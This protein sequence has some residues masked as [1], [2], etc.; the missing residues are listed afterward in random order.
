MLPLSSGLKSSTVKMNPFNQ[1]LR[2]IASQKTPILKM[3]DAETKITNRVQ[4]WRQMSWVLSERRG[5][6]NTGVETV[7]H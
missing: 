6:I 3:M 2:G 4:F 1:K 5:N 7:N